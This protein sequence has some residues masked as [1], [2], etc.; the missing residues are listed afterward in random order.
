MSTNTT[1]SKKASIIITTAG[2]IKLLEFDKK[3]GN[4][5]FE[6]I[7]LEGLHCKWAEAVSL[8]MLFGWLGQIQMIVNEDGYAELGHDPKNVNLVATWLYNKL[9]DIKDTH[10][11][12]GDVVLCTE[13]NNDF[14]PFSMKDAE[15]L[16][17]MANEWKEEAEKTYEKPLV[18]PTPKISII[19][20]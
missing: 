19:P 4:E 14:A 7:K 5:F 16:I 9:Y 13:D 11:V 18:I 8:T 20:F 6:H 12:L 15:K 10:Y 1:K 2:E 3:C 17:E